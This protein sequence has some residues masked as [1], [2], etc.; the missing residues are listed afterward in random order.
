MARTGV[1]PVRLGDLAPGTARHVSDAELVAIAR[2]VPLALRGGS[3]RAAYKSDAGRPC[4]RSIRARKPK[5]RA[6]V[7]ASVVCG[8]VV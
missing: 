3:V 5:N 6:A 4:E 7:A 1:E 2:A 8:H